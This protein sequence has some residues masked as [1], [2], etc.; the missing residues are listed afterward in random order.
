MLT[1]EQ[2]FVAHLFHLKTP[3][4]IIK[5]IC[6]AMFWNSNNFED[7]SLGEFFDYVSWMREEEAWRI[8]VT[9]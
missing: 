1:D 9:C 2:K 3:M 4:K 7:P 6:G 5:E 8:G